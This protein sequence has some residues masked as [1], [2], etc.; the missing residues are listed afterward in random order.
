MKK[1]T[2]NERFI[3]TDIFNARRGRDGS[4]PKKAVAH[5]MPLTTKQCIRPRLYH[6]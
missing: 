4:N 5:H 6:T 3:S 2:L 1:A